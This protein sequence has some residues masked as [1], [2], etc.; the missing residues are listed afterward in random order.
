M[1]LKLPKYFTIP[2][3]DRII[4]I[5]DTFRTPYPAESVNRITTKTGLR[6]RLKQPFS[7]TEH[8]EETDQTFSAPLCCHNGDGV[9]PIPHPRPELC[10]TQMRLTQPNL[11]FQT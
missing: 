3:L 9:S 6:Q 5:I 2:W 7:V 1:T 8:R 10:Y 11:R 4:V